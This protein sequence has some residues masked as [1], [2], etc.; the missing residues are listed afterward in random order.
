MRSTRE[1]LHMP[2]LIELESKQLGGDCGVAFAGRITLASP[3]DECTADCK[4]RR[5]ILR[6]HGGRRDGARCHEL[7]SGRC[8]FLGPRVHDARVPE[9]GRR[10][11]ALDERA[12][13]RVAI[14]K[15]EIR[16]R[17]RDRERQAWKAGAST[18]VEDP[19]GAPDLF[20]FECDERVGDVLLHGTLGLA[21]G[22]RSM[23]I[24][25]EQI[26]EGAEA[27]TSV[28]LQFITVDERREAV[29]DGAHTAPRDRSRAMNSA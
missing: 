29:V 27:A 18:D 2:G 17:A 1:R 8:E 23:R 5:R 3:R 20:E 19:R 21:H 14:D 7:E 4:Q 25:C 22:R 15:H 28:A 10:D 16:V 24:A 12:L 9:L 6:N 26:Q 11:R 13:P